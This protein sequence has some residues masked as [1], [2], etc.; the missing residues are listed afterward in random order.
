[1]VC[2]ANAIA[3]GIP[4]LSAR[5]CPAFSCM[6]WWWWDNNGFHADC[7]DTADTDSNAYD[8]AQPNAD[9]NSKGGQS[10]DHRAEWEVLLP[11]GNALDQNGNAG[12]VAEYL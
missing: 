8:C 6:W 12:G 10:E 2:Q 7:Y 1:M 3:L 5:R 11:T 9:L 4:F